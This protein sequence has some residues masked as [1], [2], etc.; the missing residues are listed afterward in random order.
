MTGFARRPPLE[1]I[2]TAVPFTLSDS[3]VVIHVDR[4]EPIVAIVVGGILAKKLLTAH[5]AITIPVDPSERLPIVVPLLLANAAVPIAI[6][7]S[8]VSVD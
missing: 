2:A 4:V 3:S 1:R 6:K 8:G 7:A 5:D